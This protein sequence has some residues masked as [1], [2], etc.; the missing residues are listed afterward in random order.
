[1]EQ[2]KFRSWNIEEKVMDYNPRVPYDWNLN[3]VFEDSDLIFEQYIGRKD[4][5]KKDIY[6]GDI[7]RG[8]AYGHYYNTIVEYG[9]TGFIP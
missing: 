9:S 6:N 4:K 2:N 3:E 8:K 7:V 1:M 5:N